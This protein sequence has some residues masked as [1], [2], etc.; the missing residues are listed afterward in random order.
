MNPNNNQ[1]LPSKSAYFSKHPPVQDPIIIV[2][3]SPNRPSNH[4]TS[5]HPSTVLPN[6]SNLNEFEKNQSMADLAAQQLHLQQQQLLLQSQQLQQN[7]S[8]N[9]N[10]NNP[11]LQNQMAGSN[12]SQMAIQQQL[13][14][15]QAQLMNANPMMNMGN[16][17]VNNMGMNGIGMN[18]LAMNNMGI[19]NG[20]FNVSQHQQLLLLQQQ[21]QLQ[22]QLQLQ[23][24]QQ[25]QQNQYQMM[26]NYNNIQMANPTNQ[27]EMDAQAK[28]RKLVRKADI[29]VVSNTN[30]N[31]FSIPVAQSTYQ[32]TPPATDYYGRYSS[33]NEDTSTQIDVVIML[34][35][36]T[37]SDLIEI[38]GLNEDQVA[39]VKT[40][41]PIQSY[42]GWISA[43]DMKPLVRL[44]EKYVVMMDDFGTVD[45]VVSQCNNV[46]L[47][48]KKT[49]YQWGQIRAA[50]KA[51]AEALIKAENGDTE[52][53]EK[54]NKDMENLPKPKFECLT[55]QPDIINNKFTLKQY[56]LTGISWM[57]MLHDQKLGGILADEMGLG[58]TAQVVSFLGLLSLQKKIGPHLVVVPSSTLDNW[59]REINQWCPTL[60]SIAYTGS[61][62]DR[63]DIQSEI[64]EAHYNII[65]T[66]YNIATGHADDRRFLRGLKCQTLILDEGHMIKNGES[67]RAKHLKNFKIPF[68]LLITG[69]PLQN[70][71]MELVSLLTFIMPDLFEACR[72][73]FNAIFDLGTTKPSVKDL[74]N[75]VSVL[76]IQRAT[77]IMTPFVLRRRKDEVLGDLPAK[78]QVIEY[79][80]QSPEQKKLYHEIMMSSKKAFLDKNDGGALDI[81]KQPDQRK[82]ENESQ[83]KLSNVLMQLRKVTNHQL[84]VRNIYNDEKLAQ[85]SKDIVNELDYVDSNPEYVL[86]D[87]SFMSDFALHKLCRNYERMKEYV[88][89]EK[90]WMNGG[91]VEALKRLLP[92]MKKNGDRVLIFS[93]F[94]IML[95]ILEVIMATLNMKFLRLDGS[96]PSAE[97]QGLIDEYNQNDDITVFLLS[98]KACGLGINLTSANVV[99]LYDIDFNPH[100]DAQAEDRAHRVGQTRPVK[101]YKL[102]TEG[103]VEQHML[104]CANYKLLLDKKVQ[105]REKDTETSSSSSKK[106]DEIV[107][108]SRLL[109]ML[110]KDMLLEQD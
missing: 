44:I 43:P 109:Q 20:G 35:S 12:V 54:A 2:G 57:L 19:N 65:V 69:T 21:Q 24:M 70:N 13:L 8:L 9:L 77:K 11:M 22:Q 26:P 92:E 79:C 106:D 105:N 42:N 59:M 5:R 95:D 101:V 72:E 10:L 40:L 29:P 90:D 46:S 76:R 18:N 108:D 53:L 27:Y 41:R 51:K 47:N 81:W 39:I 7:Q 103:T 58:K 49:M 100:N 82:K 28:R 55:V 80:K 3:S 25:L 15:Q 45:S 99:I 104:T 48:I 78:T 31:M 74:D 36:S 110:H 33:Y 4:P 63:R 97:R 52:A 62:P 88:L 86:E 66:T 37:G 87:M 14:L 96:T 83:S 91:K 56:Q 64:E 94:V 75:N 61:Q 16:L 93:Q 30:N 84:L 60:H 85:M 34:N 98:T 50:E 17:G 89:E 32:S 71:L 68:R 1:Q 102:I 23:R 38:L 67:Q 107:E 73:N 6:N